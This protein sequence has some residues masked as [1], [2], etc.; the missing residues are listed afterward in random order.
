LIA[1]AAPRFRRPAFPVPLPV[2]PVRPGAPAAIFPPPTEAGRHLPCHNCGAALLFAPGAGA[3]KC[4][5]CGTVNAP[6][7]ITPPVQGAAIE[8]LDY[9]TYLR[10]QAGAEAQIEPRLVGCAACGAQTELPANVVAGRCA[11]CA[12]PLV[13]DQAQTRRL[14]QPRALAPFT[15]EAPAAQAAFARWIRGLWFAPGALRHAVDRA[16]DVRGVYLPYWTF[17]A[18]ADS[19]YAGERGDDRTV[20]EHRG[21]TTAQ[22]TV[23]DWRP[24][25]GQVSLRFDDELVVA[26]ESIPAHLARVLGGWQLGALVPYAHDY[27]AGF[28]VEAYRTGLEQGF[29]QAQQRFDVAITNAVRRDI[30]GDRQRIHQLSTRLSD[31]SFKHVL[32]PVW[33]ASYRFGGAAYRIVI[34][35]QTGAIAGDRPYSAWKIGLA[36]AALVLLALIGFALSGQR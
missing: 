29:A 22:R 30:G 10:N 6:P 23:T 16:E 2:P 11:F 13:A 14:I 8:E 17:D 27:L 20:S 1:R 34:N 35:G 19:A 24:A 18:R 31:I 26:S 36:V 21:G 5:A 25:A 9:L 7:L 3:L 4:P 28:T 12:S 32:L 15:L 33:I